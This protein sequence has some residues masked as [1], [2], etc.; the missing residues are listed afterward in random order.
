MY[1]NAIY[2]PETES[3]VYIYNRCICICI[4][5]IYVAGSCE[6]T[7]KNYKTLRLIGFAGT[8]HALAAI[9]IWASFKTSGFLGVKM[10]EPENMINKHLWSQG[11]TFLL[12]PKSDGPNFCQMMIRS[13]EKPSPQNV[14]LDSRSM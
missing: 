13:F 9:I 14:S 2:Q 11:L 1:S 10:T 12:A 6:C 7:C 5:F 4:C 8:I 3:I